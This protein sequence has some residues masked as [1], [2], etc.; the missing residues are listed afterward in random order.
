MIQFKL[1]IGRDYHKDYQVTGN[2]AYRGSN[3][4][5]SFVLP[6]HLVPAVRACMLPHDATMSWG[7][8]GSYFEGGERKTPTYKYLPFVSFPVR[9][10]VSWG[11]L[12]MWVREIITSSREDVARDENGDV[13]FE[14]EK[15][16]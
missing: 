5:D 1:V 8:K 11:R 4:L 13:L 6:E 3:C 2:V 9:E 7:V 16:L 12:P 14:M 10:G 15:I